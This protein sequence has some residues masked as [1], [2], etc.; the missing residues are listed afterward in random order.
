MTSKDF[1]KSNINVENPETR[2]AQTTAPARNL[3]V[4]HHLWVDPRI[5]GNEKKNDKIYQFHLF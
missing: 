2:T 1:I 3:F 4:G 5:T